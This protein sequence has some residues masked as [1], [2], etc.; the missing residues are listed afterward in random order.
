MIK[1]FGDFDVQG[2][3]NNKYLKED[4]NFDDERNEVSDFNE[5]DVIT[6]TAVYTDSYLSKI[7]RI[8]LR[9]L[10]RS[11][12]GEFGV[13]HDIVYIDGIPGVW[14]YGID[15][16]TKN[17]VCCRNRNVKILSVFN[18]FNINSINKAI[19]TY[20][21]QKLGFQD[22]IDE[23]IY[24]LTPHNVNE[25]IELN[26]AVRYGDGWTAE[27][28]TRFEKL[29]PSDREY[30]YDFIRRFG[31][32]KAISEYF[33]LIASDDMDAVRIMKVFVDGEP[34]KTGDGQTRYLMGLAD[35]IVNLATGGKS[36]AGS[37]KK[38]LDSGILDGLI[39]EYK[40]G[41][42]AIK[43]SVDDD[44]EIVD[45]DD[46]TIDG[47]TAREED[48]KEAIK[49]DTI[50]YEKT[51]R[52]LRIMTNAMCH[53]VKQNGILD[54]DDAS[55]M[56]KRGIFLTGKGGI[57]KSYTVTQVLEENHMVI[58]RDYV[59]VS[60]GSTTAESIYNY[61]YQYNGKLIVF[62]DSPDLFSTA[63]KV[64]MWKAALQTEGTDSLVSYPLTSKDDT[65]GLY[66]TG[67]LTRQERYFKEMGRKSLSEKS[68]YRE[69]RLKELKKELGSEYDKS[70]AE[71]MINDE[72]KEIEAETSP[73]MPNSFVFD[74]VVIVIGN[75]PREAIRKQVGEQ[76]WSAIVDR[77]QDYDLVP[78]SE[79]VWETIKKK[80]MDE[81]TDTSIPDDM[82]IIPRSMVE[83]F[84]NEVNNL[85]VQKQYKVMTWRL[86][87]AYGIK[88]RGKYGLED[89]KDDLKND[90]N[91]NK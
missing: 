26:E 66:K 22:M 60:S 5:D 67:T 16:N 48:R 44:Y 41:A 29:S 40:G 9:K 78:M 1:K 10:K 86:I 72:W 88:L 63:K 71:L 74:G 32:S 36:A 28:V 59:N 46:D 89:W 43:T 47:I 24:D 83:E 17:I 57:G 81:Y 52:K 90:M 13:C 31:K 75:D 54:N 51:L 77:F 37:I 53:Y 15:D 84:V 69:R 6:G 55:A 61:L 76:Q 87:R 20:S 79:S 70:S 68:E 56:I 58:N 38:A 27:N 91:T 11:G 50:K 33:D 4:I 80:I 25:G 2:Y 23:M 64:A 14:I 7:T 21:T 85:I 45:D 3:I 34:K 8:I 39:S 62:D 42:P 73:L 30:V 18:S 82:C 19:T 12:L 35:C 65:K 49:E